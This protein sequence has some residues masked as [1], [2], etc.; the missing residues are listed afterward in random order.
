M[1]KV[2]VYTTGCPKCKILEKTLTAAG[3][4]FTTESDMQKAINA[5]MQYAPC[6]SVND[7]EIMDFSTAMKWVGARNV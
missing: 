5:G 7:G 1:D 6:M 3:I 2:V 4:Q